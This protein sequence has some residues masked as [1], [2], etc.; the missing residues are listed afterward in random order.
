M[1]NKISSIIFFSIFLLCAVMS[2][3]TQAK[4]DDNLYLST[5]VKNIAKGTLIYAV[6][7]ATIKDKSPVIVSQCLWRLIN[8]EEY[9]S[10]RL[11][12]TALTAT[13]I[14][15]QQM[16]ELNSYLSTQVGQQFLQIFMG[17][18]NHNLSDAA[19]RAYSQKLSN[20]QQ[21]MPTDVKNA[22][23]MFMSQIVNTKVDGNYAQQYLLRQSD[24]CKKIKL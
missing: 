23:N 5:N 3:M 12:I 17:V 22:L 11:K 7:S 21:S 10:K 13:P 20:A 9:I 6:D 2:P 1:K 4:T 8:D 24:D 15:R 18:A 16:L 19:R 14:Q